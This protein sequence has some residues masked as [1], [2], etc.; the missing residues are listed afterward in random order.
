MSE[1][2]NSDGALNGCDREKAARGSSTEGGS[3]PET[4]SKCSLLGPLG[5][6]S[7][8]A[9]MQVHLNTRF[10]YCCC[11]FCREALLWRLLCALTHRERR[12][13]LTVLVTC[14]PLGKVPAILLQI[15]L[16]NSKVPGD[17]V[18]WHFLCFLFFF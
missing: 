9:L 4:V 12:E 10:S 13:P 14:R 1:Q 11:S 16:Q 3:D 6:I 17:V 7:P 8:E 15:L 5:K 18:T 2:V